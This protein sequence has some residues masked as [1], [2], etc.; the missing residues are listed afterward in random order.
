MRF[1]S[2]FLLVCLSAS[3]ILYAKNTPVSFGSKG[4]TSECNLP[5]P[6][7]FHVVGIGTNWV[8]LA[9]DALPS[10]EG[11]YRIRT[12]RSSDDL[13]INTTN[14]DTWDIISVRINGLVSGEQYY[15]I[16]N[17]RCAE[18]EDSEQERQ[19]SDFIALIL[20]LLV[21]GYSAPYTSTNC[22][23]IN[24]V[25]NNCIFPLTPNTVFPF[26]IQTGFVNRDFGIKVIPSG[27]VDVRFQCL[28]ISEESVYPFKFYCSNR[29]NTDP[30][31][32]YATEFIDVTYPLNGEEAL[33]ARFTLGSTTTNS[34]F[35]CVLIESGFQIRYLNP[36]PLPNPSTPPAPTALRERDQAGEQ[37]GNFAFC[38][39]NPFSDA[40]DVTLNQPVQTEASIQLLNLSGQT[41]LN[42]PLAIGQEQHTLFTEHLPNGFYMLRIEA[43]GEVQTLKVFKSE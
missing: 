17:A 3:G 13:L 1:K 19:S 11:G 8:D 10:A 26:K 4:S 20:D 31:P 32:C 27:G 37:L 38:T 2:L 7:N 9:W 25:N 28:L 15:S 40:L 42:Q 18:G 33:I 41:V 43:D 21:Q 12:F 16:I 14:V 35:S 22:T 29:I 6:E 5:A 36:K 34:I 30:P 23:I 39:P 24:G